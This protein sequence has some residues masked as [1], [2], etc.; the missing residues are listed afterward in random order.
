MA[1]VSVIFFSGLL[2]GSHMS[3]APRPRPMFAKRDAVIL[4]TLAAPGPWERPSEGLEVRSDRK[5]LISG[6][7]RHVKSCC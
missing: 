7:A 2:Q 5:P 4:V 1:N 3:H 6:W